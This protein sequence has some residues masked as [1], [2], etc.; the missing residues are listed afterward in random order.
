ML[1][2]TLSRLLQPIFVHMVTG[3]E[4]AILVI[5]YKNDQLHE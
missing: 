3:T 4:H 1:L 2:T 5:A